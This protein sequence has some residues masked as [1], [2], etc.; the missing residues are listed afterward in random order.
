MG[1]VISFHVVEHL[2]GPSLERLLRLIWRVVRPGGKVILETPNP[3]SLVVA[4]QS[5]WRDPSHQRPVHP[6]T[7]KLLSQ[8]AGFENVETVQ[9]R[10]FS[11]G[12]R[13]PEI[14]LEDL[15]PELGILA[16]RWNRIRDRLDELLYG[17]QDYALIGN[18]PGS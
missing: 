1:A 7:L 12:E 3:L 16:D 17:Y 4:A 18:R 9:F 6:E 5:F 11:S 13:L 15:S 8:Q 2:P 10:P 14:S